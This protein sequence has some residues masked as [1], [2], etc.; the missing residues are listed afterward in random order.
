M[1]NFLK[2]GVVMLAEVNG[3]LL[4]ML[5]VTLLSLRSAETLND[6]PERVLPTVLAM[7][8]GAIGAA[9]AG[10][11]DSFE[12]RIPRQMVAGAAVFGTAAL[13]VTAYHVYKGKISKKMSNKTLFLKQGVRGVAIGAFTGLAAALVTGALKGEFK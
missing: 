1:N 13:G 3:G 6:V 4:V 7:A 8:T 2:T 10:P 9:T 11:N 12:N 5:P